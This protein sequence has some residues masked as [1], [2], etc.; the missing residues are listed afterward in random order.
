MTQFTDVHL[1]N[2][3]RQAEICTG[4]TGSAFSEADATLLCTQSDPQRGFDNGRPVRNL[5][6]A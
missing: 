5:I 4:G 2:E 6:A 3:G 1:Q